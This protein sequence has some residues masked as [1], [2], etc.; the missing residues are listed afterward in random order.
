MLITFFDFETTGL[1]RAQ[2]RVIEVGAILYSTT[3]KRVLMAEDFLVDNEVPISAEISGITGIKKGM[4]DK[5]GLVSTDALAR[6]QNYFDLGE[7]VCGA[8]IIE[9]DLPFYVN[10]CIRENQEPI[11]KLPIDIKT[12]LINTEAKHLG[13]MAAD[14]GFLNPFPHGA[15]PD[16][17]TVLRLVE[18]NAEKYTIDAIVERAKSPRVYLQAMV[19]FDD[20]YKAKAR[21]YKWDAD[22]KVWYTCIK[23]LDLQAEAA[24][25]PF[26]VKR[27]DPIPFH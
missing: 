3:Q 10:W 18:K 1:D 15:L 25:A 24:A 9:F 6:L 23:E 22:R 7:A 11:A 2:D 13:Y 19:S 21:K 5:F 26:D 20:N 16:A 27:I 14:A 17:W 4:I 8:N 12:D